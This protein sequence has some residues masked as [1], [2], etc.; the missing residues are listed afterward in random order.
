MHR[1]LKPNSLSAIETL[2]ETENLRI[3]TDN[4]LY[5]LE[6]ELHELIIDVRNS[7]EHTSTQS[8]LSKQSLLQNLRTAS[9][10]L[11]LAREQNETKGKT[12]RY[13]HYLSACKELLEKV[14]EQYNIFVSEGKNEQ[15]ENYSRETR[16]IRGESVSPVTLLV[17]GKSYLREL[18]NALQLLQQTYD[19]FN[20]T[21]ELWP[22]QCSQALSKL[23]ATRESIRHILELLNST[24]ELPPGISSLSY[25]LLV[26]LYQL[27]E[28]ARILISLIASFRSLCQT[29]SKRLIRMR[30]E[31]LSKLEVFEQSYSH[32]LQNTTLFFN[33][34]SNSERA[35][36][37]LTLVKPLQ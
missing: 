32:I 30:G 19:L 12:S 22:D 33:H 31:I 2:L 28:Q 37:R 5:D 4:V 3:L 36:H 25:E 27:D 9:I 18:N 24:F 8:I 11:N 7:Q 1:G 16:Q 20:S 6:A 29:K 35:Q 23:Y 15:Q 17:R 13:Y 14:Y 26:K 10:K 21:N 34:A